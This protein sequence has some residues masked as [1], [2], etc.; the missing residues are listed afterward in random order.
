MKVYVVE[1]CYDYEG[2]AIVNVYA[3]QEAA[4]AWAAHLDA[5][6]GYTANGPHEVS[7]YEVL[8][9]LPAPGADKEGT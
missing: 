1:R 6:Y 8:T 2:C 9:D 7:E 4:D 5:E 3:T